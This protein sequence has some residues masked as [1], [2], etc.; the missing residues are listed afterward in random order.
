MD[1]I[2]KRIREQIP[3]LIGEGLSPE[4]AVELEQHRSQCGECNEYFRAL[5]ADDKLLCDFVESMQPNVA[6]LENVTMDEIR[7]KRLAGTISTASIGERIPGKR[8][9]KL[10]AVI[11]IIAAILIVVKV[12][13]SPERPVESVAPSDESAIHKA[14]PLKRS[15]E[16]L[17]AVVEAE[18]RELRRM[19]AASDIAGVTAMLNDGQPQSKIAAANY[20]AATG[21]E[22]AITVLAQLAAAWQGEPAENPFAAAIARIMTR[23]HE[24]QQE[25]KAG[26]DEKE[27][28]VEEATTVGGEQNVGCK[29]IV[30]DERGRPIGDARVLLHHNRSKR[31]VGNR[32]VEETTSASDGSFAFR[33]RIEFDAVEQSSHTREADGRLARHSEYVLIAAHS[34][35]A[36][37]WR[38]IR[39]AS[40]QGTYRIVLTKPASRSRGVVVTDQNGNPLAGVRIWLHR[41][42]NRTSPNVIFRDELI[43]PADVGFLGDVTDSAGRAIIRNLPDTYCLFRAKLKDYAETVFAPAQRITRISMSR[44]ASISGWVLAE[45]DK[46]VEGATIS[47]KPDWGNESF[48][49]VSDSEGYFHLEDLPATKSNSENAEGSY[50][51]TIGHEQY[52]AE[53]VDLALLPGESIDDLL[54]RAHSD[55]TLVECRVLE[56]GTDI[57]VAGARIQ[58]RNRIGKFSDYSDSE[59]V[60]QVRV[61][62]GTVSLSFHSPPDGVYML[63]EPKPAESSL[64]FDAMGEKMTVTLKTPPVAGFLR[65]VS[66][67]VIG[68]DGIAQSEGETFVYA[69]MGKIITSVGSGIEKPVRVSRDGRFELKEVPAGRRLHLYVATKD[70]SLAAVDVFEIPDDPDWSGL[71]TVNLEVTQN[72]STVVSDEHGDIIAGRSFKINPIVEGEPIWSVDI[73]GWTD[74]NGLLELHGIVPGLEYYLT[75]VEREVSGESSIET[76]S[77]IFRRKM[78]L[79]PLEP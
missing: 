8:A 20:L 47:L 24:Q 72:A 62:P 58:G 26:D 14:Q 53:A 69:G 46:P 66:G 50:T 76:V 63:D 49:A 35:Y 18:S 32:V 36:F 42:G 30:V 44:A 6:R 9:G 7:R 43:L 12:G 16:D 48:F 10:A 15:G 28:A 71:L 51:I 13:V 55:T 77:G 40:E 64:D 70:R 52:A 73:E 67:I 75:G 25:S 5:E 65:S 59:G 4:K 22:Q 38:N 56:F 74:E 41:A 34:N 2:C 17:Q 27:L 21:G 19:I 11:L 79:V 31:R 37:G 68:P 29:G 3:E 60:F 1:E 33:R 61:L 78:V 45:K 39:K 54:I 23:L 57:P